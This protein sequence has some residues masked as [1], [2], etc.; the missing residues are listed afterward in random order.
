MEVNK[1]KLIEVLKSIDSRLSKLESLLDNKP[2]I[3]N[4]SDTNTNLVPKSSIDFQSLLENIEDTKS[5]TIVSSIFNN[6]YPTVTYGQYK[7]ISDIATQNN[8]TI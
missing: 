8:F 1:D 2:K 7:L 5:K 3:S 4:N 6:T